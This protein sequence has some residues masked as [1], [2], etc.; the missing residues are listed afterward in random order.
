MGYSSYREAE[1]CEIGHIVKDST[2]EFSAAIS[3]I[4]KPAKP[5]R[6]KRK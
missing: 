5:K 1:D 3:D 2:A 6:G 4:F